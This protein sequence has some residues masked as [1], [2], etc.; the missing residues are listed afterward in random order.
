VAARIIVRDWVVVNVREPIPR[1]GVERVGDQGVGLDEAAQVRVVVPGVIVIQPGA[2][3]KSLAGKESIGEG[4]GQGAGEDLA[5]GVVL[6]AAHGLSGD[7]ADGYGRAQVV[8][9]HVVEGAVHA[10]GEALAVGS[11]ARE[12]PPKECN[13]FG[14]FNTLG[15]SVAPTVNTIAGKRYCK[16]EGVRLSYLF[17]KLSGALRTR[18]SSTKHQNTTYGML[19]HCR[20]REDPVRLQ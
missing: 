6:H 7:I 11:E 18:S 9:V 8:L 5:I 15:S 20:A 14:G 3:V 13:T 17:R 19:R 1:L 4:D 16:Y 12:K 10:G 2:A